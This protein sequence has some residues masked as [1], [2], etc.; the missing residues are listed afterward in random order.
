MK[1]T[2][3]QLIK[4]KNHFFVPLTI[5]VVSAFLGLAYSFLA[6]EKFQAKVTVNIPSMIDTPDSLIAK[7]QMPLFYSDETLEKCGLKDL[8]NPHENLIENLKNKPIINTTYAE[9][10]YLGS[11]SSQ[12][13]ICLNAII[14]NIKKNNED[15]LKSIKALKKDEMEFLKNQ[16]NE[17]KRYNRTSMIS[18]QLQGMIQNYERLSREISSELNISSITKIYS[19]S[20]RSEP[21]RKKSILWALFIGLILASI[22][23]KITI[24]S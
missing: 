7:L 8:K 1:Y 22:Y 3:Q 20:V 23:I 24:K 6:P 10:S 9:L 18:S 16:I 4:N 13:S 14:E 17:V 15:V 11:S 12:A 5:T 21:S 2:L 19:P